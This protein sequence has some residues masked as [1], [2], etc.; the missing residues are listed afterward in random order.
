MDGTGSGESSG[1]WPANKVDNCDAVRISHN[2]SADM[3]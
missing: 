2:N 3:S 1:T